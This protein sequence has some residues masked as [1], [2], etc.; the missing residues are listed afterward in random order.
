MQGIMHCIR[1]PK[2]VEQ[3]KLSK[4]PM[5]EIPYMEVSDSNT[6]QNLLDVV[7]KMPSPR[8]IKSHLPLSFLQRA[9]SESKVKVIVVIRNPKDTMVSFY[10][11]YRAMTGFGCFPGPF[12]EF[13]DLFMNGQVVYGDWFD[14]TLEFWKQRNNPN[15]LIVSYEEMMKEPSCV[16]KQMATF[17]GHN[18][19]NENATKIAKMTSFGAMKQKIDPYIEKE[20]WLKSEISPFMRKGIV[21]DWRNHFTVA[22]NEAFDKT[23]LERMAGS[24]LKFT[25]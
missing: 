22:Q 25:F 10:H 6:G 19:S 24:G 18:I 17:M 8:M 15:F 5:E 20:G 9:I 13:Y 23:Y 21:G 7:E 16:I 3:G 11:F 14:Y 2:D 12:Q 4:I 1:T